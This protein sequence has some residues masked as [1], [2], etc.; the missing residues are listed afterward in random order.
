M[1]GLQKRNIRQKMDTLYKL[2]DITE[3]K[4]KKIFQRF[5]RRLSGIS[6]E[7]DSVILHY[8]DNAVK[9]SG[10][11]K[12]K[13]SEAVKNVFR[14]D[15]CYFE[16]IF[17]HILFDLF[18]LMKS[19]YK[20]YKIVRMEEY[21]IKSVPAIRPLSCLSF[22]NPENVTEIR[23]YKN[24][25]K[26]IRLWMEETSEIFLED[27]STPEKACSLFQDLGRGLHRFQSLCFDILFFSEVL[28][29]KSVK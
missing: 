12:R 1:K 21:E 9:S 14:S 11:R 7:L 5:S 15:P 23:C 27:W 13:K 19:Y 2:L 25:R 22:K 16:S 8:L 20:I 6:E 3:K 4:H 24:F 29:Q 10:V 26:N 18:S 17:E 28:C